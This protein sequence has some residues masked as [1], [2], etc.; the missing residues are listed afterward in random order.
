MAASSDNFNLAV[1]RENAEKAGYIGVIA[2]HIGETSETGDDY[3]CL[4]FV[5]KDEKI[6]L[7]SFMFKKFPVPFSAN[8][9]DQD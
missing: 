5:D 4:G 1:F 3:R 7:D 9:S 6:R 8:D 2:E